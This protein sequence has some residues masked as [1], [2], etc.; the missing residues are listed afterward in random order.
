MLQQ[1]A[2]HFTDTIRLPWII[3]S[4]ELRGDENRIGGF[5]KDLLWATTNS[6]GDRTSS[7]MSPSGLRLWRDGA[8]QLVRLTVN[9]A[10]FSNFSEVSK[11]CSEWNAD[12][13]DRLIKAASAMGE[14]DTS[15]WLCRSE[16]E[17]LTKI[18]RLE[19]KSYSM[20]KWADIDLRPER[21]IASSSHPHTRGIVIGE[22]VYMARREVMPNGNIA[23]EHVVRFPLALAG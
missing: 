21:C 12:A 7:A 17:S 4:G 18:V 5:P 1:F 2:Y 11:N 14:R 20:G 13:I 16:P 15:K 22:N 6:T 23:Y 19:A 3:L 10:D 8:S 9:A